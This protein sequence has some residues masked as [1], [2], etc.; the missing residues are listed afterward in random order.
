MAAETA[1]MQTRGPE[2]DV[3]MA[4]RVR[5]A[6]NLTGFPFPVH[7][8]AAR[9]RAMT[10]QVA[11]AVAGLPGDWAL[12]IVRLETLAPLD[13]QILVEKHLASP[14]LVADPIRYEA[15]VTDRRETISVMVGE[16]DHLRLQVLLPGL[17]LEQAWTVA[18]RLDDALESKLDFAFDAARGYL[19]AYPTNVG[20]GLRASVM[21]HLPA[22]TLTR[23]AGGLFHTLAQAGVV[24]RGLYGEGSE[25]RG[26]IFQISNQVSLGRS[27]DEMVH[28]LT[29]VAEQ[30]V[31]RERHAR[32]QLGR[33][34]SVA[35]ADRVGRAFGVLGHARVLTSEEA[36][37]LLS[38]V[39]LGISL[40]LVPDFKDA[41][42]S[43][44][45]SLTRP[46]LLQR[47][48]GRELDAGERDRIRA[49]M[50]QAHLASG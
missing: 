40:G 23:E 29:V 12:N 41:T 5:L 30:V 2:G 20:T 7:L 37:H 6:R 27:E 4:S 50:I 8:D 28:A 3:V 31:G 22:L 32:E 15:V 26:S 36:L 42:F 34:A 19:T 47:Q 14:L 1:W 9:G 21:V 49:D 43:E 46:G 11:E 33:S 24:V 13:R 18:D 17:Q 35:V 16:E 38:D 44:L 45:V 25:G 39:Q 48:A 10:D